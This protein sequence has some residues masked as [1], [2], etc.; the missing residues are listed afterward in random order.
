MDTAGTETGASFSGQTAAIQGFAIP[1]NT[2]LQVAQQIESGQSSG[3]INVGSGPYIGVEVKDSNTVAGAVVEVVEAG[4]PA[5]SAGLVAGDVIV[6]L[7]NT[8]VT[9]SG[10]LSTAL[11]TLHP[12]ENVQLGW[13]DSSGQQ[14]TSS[15]TLASGPPR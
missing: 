14:H 9:S 12:G 11:E 5:A 15:I 10:D 6:S 13:V 4:T 2:A 8:Q 7:N 1:I 3:S